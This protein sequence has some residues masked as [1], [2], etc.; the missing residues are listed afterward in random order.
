MSESES[1]DNITLT[2]A[3]LRELLTDQY[4]TGYRDGYV[5]GAA[6]EIAGKVAWNERIT[7]GESAI[8]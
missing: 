4:N 3:R 2:A 5:I 1:P 7:T 8:R 6:D